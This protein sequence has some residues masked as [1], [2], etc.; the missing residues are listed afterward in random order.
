LNPEVGGPSVKPDQ[1]DGIW[2]ATT[3]G[4]GGST[5]TYITS[6]GKGLYRKSLYTFW[7]RTVPPPSMMTFDASSRDLCSVIRQETNTPLQALVLLNDPQIIEASRLLAKNA[8]DH[9]KET[10]EQIRY[11][12]KLATSRDPDEQELTVL[13]DYYAGMLEK[14]VNGQIGAQDYLS[15]GALKMDGSY[16]KNELAALALTAHTILNLDE[17]ISRG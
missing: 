5:S 10:K 6:T 13:G 12:F 9:D 15:I 8:M 14:A 17:T 11:I 2:E 16:P 4:S 1:P 7:K 3:G